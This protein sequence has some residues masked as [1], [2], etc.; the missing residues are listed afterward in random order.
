MYV[1]DGNSL[2]G[3]QPTVCLANQQ[4]VESTPLSPL[5]LVL[6]QVEKQQARAPPVS[7]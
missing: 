4:L 6:S 2:L 7:L 1:L 5:K 3:S